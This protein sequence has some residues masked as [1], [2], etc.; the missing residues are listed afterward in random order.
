MRWKRYIVTLASG[1]LTFM[2]IVYADETKQFLNSVFS[3][4]FRVPPSEAGYYAVVGTFA[5]VFF[6]FLVMSVHSGVQWARDYIRERRERREEKK[7]TALYIREGELKE[8]RDYTIKGHVR[9]KNEEPESS[10]K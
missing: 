10:N 7:R 8:G 9:P 1:V 3:W 4:L 2:S 6:V 5:V